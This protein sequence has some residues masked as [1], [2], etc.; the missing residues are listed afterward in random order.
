MLFSH[1]QYLLESA[2]WKDHDTKNDHCKTFFLINFLFFSQMLSYYYSLSC[3]TWIPTSIQR[4]VPNLFSCFSFLP[5]LLHHM[6]ITWF[7]F[8]T[9]PNEFGHLECPQE[10]RPQLQSLR[11]LIRGRSCRVAWGRIC[12]F[13]PSPLRSLSCAHLGTLLCQLFTA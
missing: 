7:S 4:L 8:M 9:G 6:S 1:V 2:Y 10:L 3:Q 12:L 11:H 13:D 5:N